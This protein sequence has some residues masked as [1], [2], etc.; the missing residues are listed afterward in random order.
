MIEN[1]LQ[2]VKFDPARPVPQI[3][4]ISPQARV[5]LL[6]V[7]TGV[8]IPVHPDAAEVIFYVIAGRGVITVGEAA[9]PVEAGMLLDAPAGAPR[10]IRSEEQMT[11]LAF[12]LG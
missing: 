9:H 11:V 3:V 7:A 2:K 10:G 6:G 1:L 12:H 4:Y 8:E 5:L